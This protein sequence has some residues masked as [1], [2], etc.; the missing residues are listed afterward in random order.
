ME[1]DLIRQFIDIWLPD[2]SQLWCRC[3]K[4]NSHFTASLLSL[5]FAD[6][7]GCLFGSAAELWARAL[8]SEM[9]GL[10]ECRLWERRGC[11]KH[12]G[13]MVHHPK[14]WLWLRLQPSDF[15]CLLDDAHKTK[16]PCYLTFPPG[17]STCRLRPCHPQAPLPALS[18]LLSSP[19]PLC[20]SVFI[21]GSRGVS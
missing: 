16:D 3:Q 11:Q 18:S 20:A 10:S 21:C 8:P 1:A 14:A 13:L 2:L 12:P 4:K 15:N 19:P 7:L 9:G 6:V 17:V 5:L